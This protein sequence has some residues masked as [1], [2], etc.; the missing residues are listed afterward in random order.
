LKG[1]KTSTVHDLNQHFL[2]CVNAVQDT[3]DVILSVMA[4]ALSLIVLMLNSYVSDI[5]DTASA[6]G[7]TLLILCQQHSWASLNQNLTALNVNR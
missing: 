7:E 6:L 3:I 4:L 1:E 2:I 5:A